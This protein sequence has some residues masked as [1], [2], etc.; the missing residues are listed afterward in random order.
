MLP[1]CDWLLIGSN[2]R[3]S[4]RWADSCFNHFWGG[5]CVA[6]NGRWSPSSSPFLPMAEWLNPSHLFRLSATDGRGSFYFDLAFFVSLRI[7][8]TFVSI[9]QGAGK[10]KNH[11]R[12]HSFCPL[13]KRVWEREGKILAYQN[14]SPATVTH[15]QSW[16]LI[17]SDSPGPMIDFNLLFIEISIAGAT[18]TVCL[19]V[20]CIVTINDMQKAAKVESRTLDESESLCGCGPNSLAVFM[21]IQRDGGLLQVFHRSSLMANYEQTKLRPW[22]MRGKQKRTRRQTPE[23]VCYQL[24]RKRICSTTSSSSHFWALFASGWQVGRVN[25]QIINRKKKELSELT[26]INHRLQ[27]TEE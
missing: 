22:E 14:K 13:F 20:F 27:L 9:G 2:P 8:I 15:G 17:T 4:R 19:F 21:Q 3:R 6:H 16:P 5:S 24:E 23:L 26:R 7:I 25:E 12:P 10:K 1:F 18:R 11:L